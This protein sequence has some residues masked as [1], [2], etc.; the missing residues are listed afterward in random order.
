MHL[1]QDIGSQLATLPPTK[2]LREQIDRRDFI[3]TENAARAARNRG[4]SYAGL[5]APLMPVPTARDMV[6]AAEASA[7]RAAAFAASADGQALAA[8]GECERMVRAIHAQL[9]RVRSA[10]SRADGSLADAASEFTAMVRGLLPEAL[11]LDM[12]AHAEAA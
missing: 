4:V 10:R 9:D 11:T 6:A 5:T 8:I 7:A 1:A 3:I 2:A 12:V